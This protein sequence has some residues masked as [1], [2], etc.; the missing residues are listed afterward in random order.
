MIPSCSPTSEHLGRTRLCRCALRSDLT[1]ASRGREIHSRGTYR[2]ARE[3]FSTL[4]QL[5]ET[6]PDSYL[7]DQP[8]VYTFAAGKSFYEP[9]FPPNTVTLGSSSYAVMWPSHKKHR[10]S[11]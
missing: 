11:S 2:L 7:R 6:D 1:P 8:H 9:L 4:F 3:R 5:L 10:C